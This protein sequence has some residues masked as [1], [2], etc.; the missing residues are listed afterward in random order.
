MYSNMHSNTPVKI[1]VSDFC[2]KVLYHGTG[3]LFILKMFTYLEVVNLLLSRY[4]YSCCTAVLYWVRTTSYYAYRG[5]KCH[6][7][8]F[9][10]N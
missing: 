3:S 9:V 1:L 6:D 4:R 10:T 2:E 7:L 5:M 8:C